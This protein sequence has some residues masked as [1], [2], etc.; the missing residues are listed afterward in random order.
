[1]KI[2]IGKKIREVL[3][4]SRL[5][6]VEFAVKINKS[7]TV[8]YDIFE[9]ESIDTKLLF[10]ISE[11]LDFDFFSFY[12]ADRQNFLNEQAIHQGQLILKLKREL[13]DCRK[14]NEL[15]A[16]LVKLYKENQKNSGTNS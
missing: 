8:V 16:G 15:L 1:V 2:H 11:V 4:Q 6:V 12:F 14:E 7:R 5:S 13:S 3:G 9:R 10:T